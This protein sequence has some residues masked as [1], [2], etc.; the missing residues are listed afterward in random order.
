MYRITRTKLSVDI[1]LSP[2]YKHS[3]SYLIIFCVFCV[4][5]LHVGNYLLLKIS[6]TY[7]NNNFH[8]ANH[9]RIKLPWWYL[10]P[11]FALYMKILFYKIMHKLLNLISIRFMYRKIYA[12]INSHFRDRNRI[13]TYN[14]WFKI[15]EN[16]HR[17]YT[18]T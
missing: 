1:L 8:F 4:Y 12:L 9:F 13:H 15:S 7:S 18:E 2:Q 10:Y 16:S 11:N 6:N 14:I 5:S 3:I 17:F